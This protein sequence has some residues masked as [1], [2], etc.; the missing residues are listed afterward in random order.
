MYFPAV[1]VSSQNRMLITFGFLLCLAQA[2]YLGVSHRHRHGD[3][4]ARSRVR[5]TG[6]D[7]PPEPIVDSYIGSPRRVT[8]DYTYS[9]GDSGS[10]KSYFA[11]KYKP[12]FEDCDSYEPAILEGLPLNSTV[13]TV[14]AKDRDPQNA[15]GSITY[16]IVETTDDFIVDP[17]SGL[18]TTNKIFDRDEPAREKIAYLT[19]RAT[20]NGRPQLD[21]VCNLQ[22][23]ILDKNDNRPMFDKFS[24]G[25]SIPKDLAIGQVV[26]RISATDIDDGS[27]GAVQYRLEEHVLTPF[28]L[29]IFNITAD[30]GEIKLRQSPEER[31][32]YLTAVARDGGNPPEESR[33]NLTIRVVEPNQKPPYFVNESSY[34]IKIKERTFSAGDPVFTF[35]ANSGIPNNSIVFFELVN[36]QTQ[37]T[38]KDSV[39][40]QESSGNTIAIK[41]E[42]PPLDYELVNEYT[43]TIRVVNRHDLAATTVLKIE[44]EDEN[45]ERPVFNDIKTGNV[46]EN[47]PNGTVVMRV[48]AIDKDGTSP[49]NIVTYFLDAEQQENFEIDANTGEI[50]TRKMFDREMQDIYQVSVIA[51]DGA[52]SVLPGVPEGR[53]NERRETIKIEIADMNDNPPR[54]KLLRY[55]A[56]ILENTDVGTKVLDVQATDPDTESE[57]VYSIVS[58]DPEKH[59]TIKSTSINGEIYIDKQLDYEK[60]RE[61]I[62]KVR[63]SDSLHVADTEVRITV[64]NVNDELPIFEEMNDSTIITEESTPPDCIFRVKAYDPDIGS[65]SLPQNISYSVLVRPNSD[66]FSVDYNGCVRVIKGLDRDPPNG[67]PFHQLFIQASDEW[68]NTSNY[69]SR[70]QELRVNLTDV[71]D[72]APFLNSINPVVWYENQNPGEI[73]Q[74]TAADHD[75]EHN[76]P[77]FTFRISETAESEI[78]D[79]FRIEGNTLSALKKDF[80]RELKR[81]YVIPILISDSGHPP[82]SEISKL[83]VIIG[84]RNDNPM[85]P[86]ES[87]IFVYKYKENTTFTI[88]SVFVNDLDDWDLPDKTFYWAN[89]KEHSD[90]SLAHD[91]GTISMRPSA[92]TGI[93]NLEFYVVDDSKPGKAENVSARVTVTVKQIT[94]EAVDNSGSIRFIGQK[95]E[96]FVTPQEDV[97]LF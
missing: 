74:L 4:R 93:Y 12:K 59:F 13:L 83:K 32:Y 29:G 46:L 28:A 80:D 94:D 57:I 71:N 88:G 97:S 62:L 30:T 2:E 43:L 52:E 79:F 27:N 24:Y 40:T 75:E 22:V 53:P 51:R 67:N 38:N 54:F 63:A 21:D 90:F 48:Q 26:M 81:E 11:N 25:E 85:Y 61:Y 41:V 45:D 39:F 6:H 78:K 86:G 1:V 68:G 56:E 58:G 5:R 65:R 69:K 34:P 72:N 33:T 7:P 47:E 19:V 8:D 42:N 96:D 20:D 66:S 17:Y 64:T 77:P 50:K 70:L 92:R 82:Q 31:T 15:G 89:N 35:T 44:V 10:S 3:D 55:E 36:G 9:T 23:Q 73:M 14:R 37:A 91:S 95:K 76:G 87:K 18:I 60:V 49:N 84:D 16:S